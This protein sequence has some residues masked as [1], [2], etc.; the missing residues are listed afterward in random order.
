MS[1]ETALLQKRRDWS[2]QIKKDVILPLGQP[3]ETVVKGIKKG[4]RSETL[5]YIKKKSISIF[6]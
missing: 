1:W 3:Y 5:I 6:N 4:E 2:L